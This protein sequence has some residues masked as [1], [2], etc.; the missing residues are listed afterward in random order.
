M[1]KHRLIPVLILRNG[2]V[3]QSLN[4]RHTNIIHF[5]P[6]I[7]VDFFDR[8]AVDEM[9]ILDV[10]PSNEN[11]TVF[12]QVLDELSKKC[13]VPL[14]V[15]GWVKS[16]DDIR[17]LMLRGAD[18]ITINTEAFKR[19][20]LI[21]ECANIFGSQCIVVSIDTK[22]NID[23]SYEVFIDRGK[24]ATGISPVEWSKKAEEFGAGEI[25][26]TSIDHDGS[27]K[28]Y[29]LDLMQRV[30]ESVNIPVVAFGGVSTWQHLVDGIIIGHVDAVSAANV[31]HYTENSTKKAKDFMK[32]FG[33]DVR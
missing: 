9:L 3:V 17:N 24:V 6:S 32:K 23:G 25:F 29:D 33:L 18:K 11:R 12:L 21:T 1:L 30:V 15:G 13:F 22:R 10:S 28:G 16:I 14:S 7:A 27:R 2:Q 26:L 31:F 20:E 19:P 8:W 4:F 5:N